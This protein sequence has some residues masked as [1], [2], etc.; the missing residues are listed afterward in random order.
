MRKKITLACFLLASLLG[1]FA[2]YSCSNS[3]DENLE[4]LKESEKQQ[5]SVSLEALTLKTKVAEAFRQNKTRSSETVLTESQIKELRATALDFL[6]S[7]DMVKESDYSDFMEEGDPRLILFASFCVGMLETDP[8]EL[9]VEEGTRSSDDKPRAEP[10]ICYD[11]ARVIDCAYEA[12]GAFIGLNEL[13]DLF[14]S[15]CVTIS[16][17]KSIFKTA[18]KKVPWLGA[19]AAL[20]RF[21]SCMGWMNWLYGED[22]EFS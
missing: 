15:G 17:G 16:K 4:V 12:I 7:E 11:T 10:R 2:I 19:M 9:Y 1:T 6:K 13:K 22:Y 20:E 18:L 5:K 21:C 3:L 8:S 14:G